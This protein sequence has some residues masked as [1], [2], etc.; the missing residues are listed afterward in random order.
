MFIENYIHSQIKSLKG[1]KI[2]DLIQLFRLSPDIEMLYVFH[3]NKYKKIYSEYGGM[4][5]DR[6]M[7]NKF[8]SSEND[9]EFLNS[10]TYI[11]KYTSK[12]TTFLIMRTTPYIFKTNKSY[13]ITRIIIIFLWVL[14]FAVF[15]FT[16]LKPFNLIR[17]IMEKEEIDAEKIFKGILD[18]K[19]LKILK[20]KQMENKF[21]I[22]GH[23]TAN[24]IHEINNIIASLLNT[25]KLLEISIKEED[26]EIK[27]LIHETEDK[28]MELK[29]VLNEYN[30]LMKGRTEDYSIANLK[31]MM[32]S[33]EEEV[34]SKIRKTDKNIEIE[35][36]IQDLNI[37]CLPIL[38][39]KLF[40]NII[41]NSIEAIERE[42]KI[43]IETKKTEDNIIISIQDNGKG[44]DKKTLKNIF[45]PFFTT[46]KENLGLG[47]SMVYQIVKIQGWDIKVESEENKGTKIDI[48][49][50]FYGE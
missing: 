14:T 42:G 37:K 26:E 39:Q 7:M 16:I 9:F 11:A 34:K 25:L 23:F 1:K 18:K 29:Q 38:T 36:N 20:K 41:N 50:P 45:V 48:I 46:K 27:N 33:I 44:M 31:E 47:L 43:R 5:L 13:E 15:I 8:I 2:K 22:L 49:I 30:N 3:K 6:K 28:I 17:E 12:D 35:K 19:T 4:E 10:N 32:D 24:L 21:L 40:F